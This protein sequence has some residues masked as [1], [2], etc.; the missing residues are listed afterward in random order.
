MNKQRKLTSLVALAIVV[1]AMALGFS[2]S[3]HAQNTIAMRTIDEVILHFARD[4]R[5]CT[6]TGCLAERSHAPTPLQ[7]GRPHNLND[8]LV[9]C[10]SSSSSSCQPVGEPWICIND[11]GGTFSGCTCNGLVD[12]GLLVWEKGC[13]TPLVPCGDRFC[14]NSGPL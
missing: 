8:D 5:A 11:G 13:K 9:F 2:V 4:G 1:G 6:A 7:A 14:C 3:A 10:T 12:C